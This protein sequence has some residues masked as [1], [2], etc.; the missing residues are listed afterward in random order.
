MLYL[1]LDE[2]D[3]PDMGK[4]SSPEKRILLGDMH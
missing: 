1:G 2:F 3:L 4:A